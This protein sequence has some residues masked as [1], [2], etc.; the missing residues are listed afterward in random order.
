MNGCHKAESFRG[1]ART[2]PW[3]TVEDIELATPGRVHRHNTQQLHR[4]LGCAPAELEDSFD[5]I[6][7]GD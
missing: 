1:S 7:R 3:K 2:D 6:H 4:R 5:A